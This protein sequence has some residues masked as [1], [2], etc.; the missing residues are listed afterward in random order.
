[1][2]FYNFVFLKTIY[3]SST[4]VM[5]KKRNQG[6]TLLEILL[7]VAALVILASIVILAINP[8]KQLADTRNSQRWSDVNTILNAVYQYAIDNEGDLPATIP[9]DTS[10]GTDI[11]IET[12]TA[13]SCLVDLSVLI[14]TYLV[15]I[16]TDPK[17]TTT[18]NYT[19]VASSTT[20][21]ITVSAP[22]AEQ[23]K[24]ITVTR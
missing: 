9:L 20:D 10:T 21:R 4:K 2:I 5:N 17:A 18:Q 16:P 24:T 12:D 8:G 7:A 6:F 11:C 14:P 3:K 13:S 22:L 1:M 23:S 19:V 15:D